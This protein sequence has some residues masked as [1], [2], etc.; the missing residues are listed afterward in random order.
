MGTEVDKIMVL[1]QQR[2]K[3]SSRNVFIFQIEMDA[4]VISLAAEANYAE[5]VSRDNIKLSRK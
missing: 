2:S 1:R 3:N 5:I 4:I